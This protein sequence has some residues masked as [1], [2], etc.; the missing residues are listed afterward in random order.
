MAAAHSNSRAINW[1]RSPRRGRVRS[2][3]SKIKVYSPKVQETQLPKTNLLVETK[4][5]TDTNQEAKSSNKSARKKKEKD[6]M[7]KLVL[8]AMATDQPLNIVRNESTVTVE[9]VNAHSTVSSKKSKMS[10]GSQFSKWLR[11][12]RKK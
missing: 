3:K 11:R 2:N 7:E 6:S 12:G 8:R 4:A 9:S 1:R 5:Y 10:R